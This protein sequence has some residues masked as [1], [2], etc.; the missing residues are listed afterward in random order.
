MDPVLAEADPKE[1]RELYDTI[2]GISPRMASNPRMMATA[3]KE[4]I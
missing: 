3:L 4:A 2:S 1:V